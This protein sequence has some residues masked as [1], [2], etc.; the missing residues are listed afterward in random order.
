ME[1]SS[2]DPAVPESIDQLYS[3][4]VDIICLTK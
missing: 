1:G 3:P 4:K 2:L